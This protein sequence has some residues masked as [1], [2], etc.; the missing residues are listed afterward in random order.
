MFKMALDLAPSDRKLCSQ[1][2]ISRLENVEVRALLRMARA[3]VDLYCGS[4]GQGPSRS[5]STSTIRSM[6]SMAASSCACSMLTTTRMAFSPSSS[7]VAKAASSPASFGP[8][9]DRA[10]R[11]SSPFY[12]VCLARSEAI[13][14]R[15]KSCCAATV[16]IAGRRCSTGAAPTT[17]TTPWASQDLASSCP[18]PRRQHDESLQGR[19]GE[20]QSPKL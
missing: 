2:T 8:P 16:I 20:R 7:S 10:A 11:R 12:T 14:R 3:M 15:R 1:S 17:S 5:C 6:P 4:F 18:G 9:N 13:G 19:S